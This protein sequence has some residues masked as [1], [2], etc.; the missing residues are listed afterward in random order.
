MLPSYVEGDDFVAVRD[1]RV[2]CL[3][4]RL[5]LRTYVLRDNPDHRPGD[6]ISHSV[7][8]TWAVHGSP[9]DAVFHIGRFHRVTV[10]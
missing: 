1:T 9:R 3:G 5:R 6:D 2:G 7:V 4:V 8:A 10:E